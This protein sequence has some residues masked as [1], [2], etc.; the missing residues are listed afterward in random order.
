VAKRTKQHK[1]RLGKRMFNKIPNFFLMGRVW[2]K[3]SFGYLQRMYTCNFLVNKIDFYFYR[4]FKIG[5][6]KKILRG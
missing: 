1:A 2:Y 6:F 4:V 5:I 3:N